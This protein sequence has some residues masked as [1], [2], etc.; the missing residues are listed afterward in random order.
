MQQITD[1]PSVELKP[2]I[3]PLELITKYPLSEISSEF[4]AAAR[5]QIINIIQGHD[6][7]LLV[8]VG[9]CSIHDVQAAYDYAEKL[10]RAAKRFEETLFIL[11]RVYFEKPR[12]VLGWGGFINDPHLNK[13]FDINFGLEAARRLL[14]NIVEL[15]V[16]TATEFLETSI[17]RYYGDL[18]CWNAVGARTVTS[19]I[20]RQLASSLPMSVGF[21]NTT[22]GN[23]KMAIDAMQ[24]ARH[25]HHLMGL[26][27]TGE[28]AIIKTRGNQ[29]CHLILRGSH[30][31]TN[32]SEDMI[33]ETIT[34]LK[35]KNLPPRLMVDCSHG[36][37]MKNYLQQ[38]HVVDSLAKIIKKH[39]HEICGVMLESNLIAGNQALENHKQ[40]VYGQSITDGCISWE[41]TLLELEKLAL[42][43][44]FDH[45]V[46]VLA[47]HSGLEKIK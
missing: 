2:L 29:N 11:M 8:I 23:I 20:H 19:Q 15:G 46:G 38:K 26:S 40:L 13:T 31:A 47:E 43:K 17:P 7:R 18:I 25:S 5:Q 27:N 28:P 34:L 14:L 39:N 44:R 30:H 42:S 1:N 37:S 9:P 22:D 35:N 3:K 21:K 24:V 36:N 41:E 32:Y 45:H 10:Q 16:P 33:S 12:T 4:I 6:P